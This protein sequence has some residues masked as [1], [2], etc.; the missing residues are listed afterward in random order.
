MRVRSF[1]LF[2]ARFVADLS[3][4]FKS[5]CSEPYVAVQS[6]VWR[7]AINA[8]SQR[9]IVYHPEL[10]RLDAVRAI[11]SS[12]TESLLRVVLRPFLPNLYH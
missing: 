3:V 12:V 6:G 8:T 7:V 9:V 1:S 4:H 5:S 11:L 10:L 2:R